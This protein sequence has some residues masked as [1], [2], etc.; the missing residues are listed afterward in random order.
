MSITIS[1]QERDALYER[2]VVRLNGIDSVY[3]AVAEEDWS[4]AQ[5]LGEEFSDLL[6]LVCSGLGWGERPGESFELSTP[7]DVI[8]RVASSL[9]V[10]ARRDLVHQESESRHAEEKAGEAHYLRQTCDRLLS[11]I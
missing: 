3:Q 9:R 5:E 4:T 2:I 10:L 7:P 1:A 6:R 8:R 11:K